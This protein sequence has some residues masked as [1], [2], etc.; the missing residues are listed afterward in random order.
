MTLQLAL[1]T[2]AAL[3]NL[4][5]GCVVFLRN[6]RGQI[7]RY[8]ALFS[9]C[10]AVWTLSSTF[11]FTSEWR[12]VW[13]RLAFGAASMIPLSFLLF[14]SVFPSSNPRPPRYLFTI[15]KV[16]GVSAFFLSFTPLIL[17]QSGFLDGALQP[18][19]GPLYL[20]F[21]VY[22][23]SCLGFSLF[24]LRQKL[25][26]LKGFE[27]LQVRYLLLGVLTSAIGAT[28]TNLLIPSV[29]HTSQFSRYGPVFGLWMSAMISHSIIRYRLMEIKLVIQKGTVYVCA[30]IAA[31]LVFV[32][33]LSFLRPLYGYHKDTISLFE[34]LLGA[35]L[36]AVLFQPLK[37]WIERSFNRYLY[38]ATYDYQ[39]T[40]RHASRRLS[41]ILDLDS[42]LDYLTTAIDDTFNGE[43]VAVYLQDSPGKDFQCR[44]SKAGDERQ[45]RLLPL[46]IPENSPLAVYLGLSQ[47]ALVREEA[48]RNLQDHRLTAAVRQL[49]HLN[50]D[51]IFPLTDNGVLVGMIIVGPK[52]SG[53]PYFADDI[54][55][56]ETL[57]S[58]AAVATKN[59]RLYR[60]VVLVNEYLDNILSTMDSGVIAVDAAGNISLFNSAAERLTGLRA[61]AVRGASC[62]RLPDALASPL[63][64]TLEMHTPGSQFEVIIPGPQGTNVPLVCSTAILEHGAHSTRGAL[65]VFS[66]LTR[67]KD[68]ER[69]KRRAERL[70]SFGT[71]ASGVAHE[72]K[73]PLVAIRTF[74]ELLPER[75]LDTDFREDFSKVVIREIARID[76]LVGRLRGIAA[77]APPQVGQIDMREPIRDTLA[78]LRGQ[79]EQARTIVKCDFQDS[80]PFVAV[81]EA[82]LK[83]LFLNLLLNSIEAMGSGGEVTVNVTRR[84]LRGSQWIVADVSDTG[85]GIPES[86][87]TTVFNP[88]FTTK[89]RGSGLGLAICRGIVDA[90]RGTIRAENRTDR[91]GARIVIE[92][93]ANIETAVVEE[94]AA[95]HS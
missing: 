46:A 37:N 88:F 16:A 34:A 68:L 85:P 63:R 49:Q 78:L 30:I 82:Q 24:L 70:A 47:R 4:T 40:I 7:H 73:N 10:V 11:V 64:E 53:D 32:L 57:V 48:P 21:G 55:L 95:L 66:D 72:I 18:V 17:R 33:F 90:H 41:T 36:L 25:T 19:Y 62:T 83:Q 1:I 29:F 8:F 5:L 92:F 84:E 60:E 22:F 61:E 43:A 20:P 80:R 35:L 2:T 56:L 3:A 87:R 79:L 74:A 69:E 44:L 27:R 54:E 65:V 45:R 39:R 81:E 50:A 67:L 93:P 13:G 15:L 52:R 76:D 58:Q 51:A 77:T 94:H 75:F 86:L 14:V 71:L 26:L 12:A 28:V 6:P 59:A 89:P 91:P 9:V 38:R 23:V 42:L 31:A